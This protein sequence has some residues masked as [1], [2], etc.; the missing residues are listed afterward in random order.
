MVRCLW[1]LT[2]IP[3]VKVVSGEWR[4]VEGLHQNEVVEEW[5]GGGRVYLVQRDT[6]FQ[7]FDYG[8]E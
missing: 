7:M 3:L 5:M 8:S 6:S 4:V 2:S 1:H